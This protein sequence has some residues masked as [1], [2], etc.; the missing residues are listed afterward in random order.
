M[1]RQADWLRG[2]RPVTRRRG[3][4]AL[5]PGWTWVEE[6]KRGRGGVVVV[7]KGM[8]IM[9]KMIKLVSMVVKVVMLAYWRGDREETVVEYGKELVEI[10]YLGDGFKRRKNMKEV[11]L[12]WKKKNKKR[13]GRLCQSMAHVGAR[14]S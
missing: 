7:M 13:K 6:E 1:A 5:S 11:E 9:M 12:T 14:R 4:M 8:V 10:M 3:P 2:R